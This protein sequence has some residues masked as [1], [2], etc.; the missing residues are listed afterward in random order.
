MTAAPAGS[1]VRAIVIALLVGTAAAQPARA[2]APAP[3]P[4]RFDVRLLPVWPGQVDGGAVQ[5]HALQV[6]GEV[7]RGALAGKD[8][9]FVAGAT[10]R[11]V[12]GRVSVRRRRDALPA[13]VAGEPALG[14]AA[15]PMRGRGPNV[16]L[17]VRGV[18]SRDVFRLLAD[19]MRVNLVV[20]V[21]DRD[22]TVR[23]KRRPAGGVLA[24]LARWLGAVLDRPAPNLIVVRPAG[25]PATPRLPTGGA[26]LRLQAQDTRAGHLV[27]LLR[28]LDGAPTA[29]QL[30]RR[31][32]CAPGATLDL[33]LPR[34]S[35]RTAHAVI[36]LLGGVAP[37]AARCALPPLPAI[38]GATSTDLHLLALAAR[39]TTR[40]AAVEYRSEV[41]VI[42]HGVDRWKIDADHIERTD[43][44]GD[45]VMFSFESDALGGLPDPWILPSLGPPRPGHDHIPLRLA[46][47]IIDGRDRLAIV[48]IRNQWQ[49]WR[50]GRQRVGS[51]DLTTW[52]D[53]EVSPGELRVRGVATP[54]TL[55]P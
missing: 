7:L 54:Y 1:A 42:R 25:E 35:T 27:E 5:V 28:Q 2:P 41:F 38:A 11:R 18:S 31:N 23:V 34:A 40:V 32:G 50:Q 20:R 26:T 3:A 43:A 46:A 19:V 52:I 8:W 17:D 6:S 24:A 55:A 12:S 44:A 51:G 49:V 16:D 22:V 4:E 39:G 29:D 47:T 48:E 37:D 36:E 9:A 21:P 10:D 15:E 33:R 14:L 13:L 53:L 45:L 30:A